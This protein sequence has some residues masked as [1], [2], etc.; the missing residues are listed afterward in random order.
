MVASNDTVRQIYDVLLKHVDLATARKI[1]RDLHEV[2]GNKSFRDTIER[3]GR[4]IEI[5]SSYIR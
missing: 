4:L 2:T 3:L 5:R 1:V